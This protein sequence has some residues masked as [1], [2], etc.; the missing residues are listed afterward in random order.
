MKSMIILAENKIDDHVGEEYD[1]IMVVDNSPTT[2][3]IQDYA[4]EVV[5]HI[6]NL[7]TEQE[8]KEH[9]SVVVY[10]DASCLFSAMLVNLQIIMKKQDDI[11]ITLP[12][13][14]PMEMSSLDKE[15]L[16]ELDEEQSK[17]KQEI[18]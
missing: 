8:G 14:K 2:E 3:N 10:L 6:R 12:W 9:R 13:D 4:N 18:E 5:G 1:V 17:N 15:T 11:D 7:W 16:R